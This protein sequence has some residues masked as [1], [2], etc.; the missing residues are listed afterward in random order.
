VIKQHLSIAVG[1]SLLA[2]VLAGCTSARHMEMPSGP[3]AVGGFTQGWEAPLDLGQNNRLNHLYLTDAGL[4]VYTDQNMVFCLSP[5]GGQVL[6]IQK[7][8]EP[9]DQLSAPVQTKDGTAIAVNSSIWLLDPEG[10]V[11][12]KIDIGRSIR[13]PLVALD[14]FIFCGV[15]YLNGGRLDKIDLTQPYNSIRWELMTGRGLSARPAIYQ[16]AI[17][18]GGE[19]GN[20]Y[21]V[22]IDRAALWPLNHGAFTT[23]GPIVAALKVDDYGLYVPSMD[24]KLYCVN[25]ESGKLMW[26]YFAGHPLDKSP[27]VSADTVYQ[28]ISNVG[29]AAIDKTNG[30]PIRAPRWLV[31][32]AQRFLAEDAQYAYLR[33]PNNSIW[34]V[35]KTSGQIKLRSTRNDLSAFVTDPHAQAIYVA[36][37][38]GLVLNVKPVTTPGVVGQVVRSSDVFETVAAA[39]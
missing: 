14:D 30:D 16:S 13:S 33:G 4:Y 5:S 1:V 31:K 10:K 23:G 29:V 25:R 35:D 36:T 6:W 9:G 24:S 7:V 27:Q 12:R 8:G 15:D 2:S 26:T 34:G 38:D 37:A 11:M 3:I 28:A 32:G 39:R 22:N 19:D 21:A 20:V 17:Y 18:A